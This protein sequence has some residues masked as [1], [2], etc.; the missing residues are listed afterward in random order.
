MFDT[1]FS[2]NL[3]NEGPLSVKKERGEKP[4]V[5]NH[6]NWKFYRLYITFQSSACK[7]LVAIMILVKP[8]VCFASHVM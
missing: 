7:L 6:C 4:D 1:F 5:K 2:I 8:R 3:N